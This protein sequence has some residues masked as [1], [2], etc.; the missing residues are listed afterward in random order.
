[1]RFTNVS[2][3]ELASVAHMITTGATGLL[4]RPN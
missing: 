3:R 2:G 1:M 4:V